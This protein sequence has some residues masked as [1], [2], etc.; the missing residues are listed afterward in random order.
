M[1]LKLKVLHLSS[2]KTWRGGEQQIAYLIDEL[3]AM[4]IENLVAA[5][6]DSAFEKYCMS[7]SIN[8]KVFPFK[9][10]FDLGT[11][12]GIK[13]LCK[14]EKIDIIHMHS[15]KS[16]GIGV[17][18]A[19]LGNK[20]P[21][22]L[23][24]RVDFVPKQNLLTRWKYNHGA[25]KRIVGVSDKITSIMKHYVKDPSLCVTV[26]S[27]VDLNKFNKEQRIENSLRKEF[28]IDDRT[29][30]IGNTSALEAHKDYFTFIETIKK[31]V[32]DGVSL[33]ALIIGEGSLKTQ[34]QAFAGEKGLTNKVIFTGFRK[35]ITRIL[36]DLDVFLMTSN[37]EGLGTS[38]LDAFLAKVPVVA[39][40]AGGIPEMVL[41]EQT[42]ML[43]PIADATTLA[44]H[45][46]R[47]S[48]DDALRKSVVNGASNKVAS[49]FSK[50][51][52][53]KKTLA[54]YREVLGTL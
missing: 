35:D 47:I 42:G 5:R 44:G 33:Q 43:A 19:V 41:H 25:I 36:P 11:A 52:T 2:E 39:T 29:L 1:E 22:I 12:L 38:V 3:N 7:K 15:S 48:N 16:H 20:V 32:D 49:S 46:K 8:V 4:G 50:E 34:L 51:M 6:T 23:S 10:S 9:N 30:L 21:L 14:K 26:H 31:L 37:E 27:G 17:L 53:A 28:G 18:S 40:A 13:D 24:R 54:V 45:V